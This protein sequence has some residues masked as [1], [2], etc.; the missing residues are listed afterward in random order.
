MVHIELRSQPIFRRRNMRLSRCTVTCHPRR[1]E[2]APVA[3]KKN[4]SQSWHFFRSR[5]VHLQQPQ[6]HH[7]SPRKNH[8]NTTKK[9]PL[10]PKP[11]VKTP[12]SPSEKIS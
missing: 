5:K 6:N 12:L 10:L 7:N 8:Q 9:Y 4:S 1:K 11:R 2:S 3:M